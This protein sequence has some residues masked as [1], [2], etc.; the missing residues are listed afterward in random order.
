MERTAILQLQEWKNSKSRKPLII[1]GARQVGKTT[2]IN[3][4]S[5]SYKQY[6]YLNLERPEHK[7]YF[8]EFEDVKDIITAIFLKFELEDNFDNTLI[9]ID[10]IQ[11]S[12]KAIALLRYFYEDF[13]ALHVVAAG[14]LLEFALDQVKNFPVGRVQYLYMF[15]LNFREFLSALGKKSALKAL[16]TVPISATA[17]K[18]LLGYFNIY[19]ILGGMPEV[20]KRYIETGSMINLHDIYE[21]IW[22][23]YRNDVK[24]YSKNDTEEKVIY[25]IISSAHNF[26][27]ERVTFQNFGNSNYRSREVGEA[28]RSLDDAKVIQ[29]IYP[30]TEVDFPIKTDYNKKPRM[31]FLDSGLVNYALKI[32]H[33]LVELQ[34]LSEAY[35]GALI[36]HLVTQ[37]LISLNSFSYEKPHFWVREKK[38]SSAEVD[39]VV[40]HNGMVIPIEIKSGK[41]GKLK[42]LHQFMKQC[43]H[44]YAIRMYAGEFEVSKI[45]TASEKPF[46]LLNLPYYLGTKIK[47]YAAWLCQNY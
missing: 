39:L 21:G 40:Y 36:P 27:D 5:K 22:S 17:H 25:H 14:S 12:P 44:H 7:R 11:E 13:P 18:I 31:Q 26:L 28:F 23:T 8:E 42:S 45:E 29:L 30:T 10:E 15:P 35:R 47:E 33:E 43:P 24:K 46:I 20:V 32:Q 1:R 38:Q 16:D 2:L 19:A 6:I 37:E 41:I 34:D 3:I 9:F 4:F